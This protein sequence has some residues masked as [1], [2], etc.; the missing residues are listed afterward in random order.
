MMWKE[1]D[2]LVIAGKSTHERRGGKPKDARQF[3]SKSGRTEDGS[4]GRGGKCVS[5]H[6]IAQQ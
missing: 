4:D 5:D 1:R 3:T 6:F 2:R